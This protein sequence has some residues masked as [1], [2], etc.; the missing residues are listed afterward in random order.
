MRLDVPRAFT[1][2]EKV[3]CESNSARALLPTGQPQ[4]TWQSLVDEP[5]PHWHHHILKSGLTHRDITPSYAG[6]PSIRF[7]SL[8][9]HSAFTLVQYRRDTR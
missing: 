4:A 7:C 6:H 2:F 9:R 1:F 5:F 3:N 8:Q